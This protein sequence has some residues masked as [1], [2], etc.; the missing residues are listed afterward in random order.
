[1]LTNL[2]CTRIVI[3]LAIVGFSLTGCASSTAD[4]TNPQGSTSS[5]SKSSP[6]TSK[7]KASASV[8]Q[9]PASGSS[10]EAHRQGKTP[11]S[12]PLKEIFFAFDRYELSEQARSALRENAAWLKANPAAKIEIEGHC[13]ERGTT[14]YNLALGAKRAGAARDYLLSLG[15]AAG[16]ISSTSFGE[17]LPM[18][19]ESTEDCYQKNRRD[20]FVVLRGAPSS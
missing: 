5:L 11:E 3:V 14:E 20:R 17:E 8:S 7:S 9:G 16:R 2:T 19:K 10:L 13:D 4:K 6:T 18:C 12:G 15:V 1:M